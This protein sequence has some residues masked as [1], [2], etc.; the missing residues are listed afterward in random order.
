M[1]HLDLAAGELASLT[2]LGTLGDLDLKLIGI[3]QVVGIHA[4]SSTCNLLDCRPLDVVA[5]IRIGHEALR[6]LAS[7][8]CKEN[9]AGVEV[10]DEADYML[11]L[12]Q[13]SDA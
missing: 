12:L 11:E 6:I 3:R 10:S 1:P 7:L 4:E 13:M 2:R 8:A 9:F 5:A